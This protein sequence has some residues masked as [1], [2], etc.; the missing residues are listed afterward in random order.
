MD[1]KGILTGIVVVEHHEPYGNFSV[2]TAG[3]AAQFRGKNIRDAFKGRRR[4]GRD[5]ASHDQRDELVARHPQQRA[6]RRP[7]ASYRSHGSMTRLAAAFV[8]AVVCACVL[9]RVP[10]HAQGQPAGNQWQFNDED[11]KEPTFAEHVRAQAVDLGVFAGFTALALVSFFRKDKTLKYITLAACVVLLGFWKSQ[12]ITIVNIFG[13]ISL[14]LPI[15]KYSLA[16]YLLAVFTVVSTV[17]WGRLYCGRMCAFRRADAADGRDAAASMALR[18]VAQLERKLSFIKYGI[19]AGAILY[20]IVP[21]DRSS[22]A[23]SSRSGCS[24]FMHVV[25]WS[26]ARGPA[27]RDGVRRNVYCRLLC[28]VGS[29]LGLI[30][31][32]TTV[33]F[34]QAW[35]E[36]QQAARSA[37]RASSG[38]R[39]RGEDHQKRV[40]CDVTTRAALLDTKSART[41]SSAERLERRRSRRGLRLL[42]K[43]ATL[44][45]VASTSLVCRRQASRDRRRSRR[46]PLRRHTEQSAAGRCG[47]AADARPSSRDAA[48]E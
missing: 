21:R 38:A 28:P 6:P 33:I 12:L 46:T 34:D 17:L 48:H 10:I 1:T 40:R 47:R 32:V 9:A 41:G 2:D 3:F 20:F 14:D 24:A 44:K 8:L 23:T 7:S 29:F 16:W 15:F 5:L 25:M 45:W 19:L 36:M 22:S 13:L 35:K 43:P 37:R 42:P 27:G 30:S 26:P 39:F 31:Q 4:R 18:T 11:E